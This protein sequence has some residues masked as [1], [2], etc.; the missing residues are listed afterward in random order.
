MCYFIFINIGFSTKI[1]DSIN[2]L[3]MTHPCYDESVKLNDEF[4]QLM[5]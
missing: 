3:Y 5:S 1:P 4:E 2:E